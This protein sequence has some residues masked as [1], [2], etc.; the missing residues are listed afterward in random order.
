MYI[1]S[2]LRT[3]LFPRHTGFG[4]K[5]FAQWNTCQSGTILQ[6]FLICILMNTGF[7]CWQ[8]NPHLILVPI[9]RLGFGAGELPAFTI[10]NASGHTTAPWGGG[11][12][13]GK[14][15][16]GKGVRIFLKWKHW[17][18][19]RLNSVHSPLLTPNKLNIKMPEKGCDTPP[20]FFNR[21]DR[22]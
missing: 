6:T 13:R 5:V 22:L 10:R 1:R 20:W 9:Q 2:Y 15:G 19:I 8:S 21:K 16:T 7:Q 12:V 4:T 18:F 14:Q 11:G 17:L 3:G